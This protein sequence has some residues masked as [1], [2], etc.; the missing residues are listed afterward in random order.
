MAH[1][2]KLNDKNIVIEVHSVNNETLNPDDEEGSGI[3]FLT[4]WSGG[5][6]H[7]VQTSY[8]GKIRYNYAG[9]GYTYNPIDDA[10]ISPAPCNHAELTLN[11]KKRWE[12]ETCAAETLQSGTTA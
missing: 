10:F 12:C 9:I 11:D 8:N 5:Y 4:Q 2:A 3:E 7:W 1:F 6:S